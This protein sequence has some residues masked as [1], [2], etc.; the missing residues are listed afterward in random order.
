LYFDPFDSRQAA[1]RNQLK[2]AGSLDA[3]EARQACKVTGDVAIVGY[4]DHPAEKQVLAA[5][6]EF[7]TPKPNP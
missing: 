6:D 2:K 5:F 1:A 3:K 4:Q 7:A